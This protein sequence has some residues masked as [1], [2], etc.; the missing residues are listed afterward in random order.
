MLSLWCLKHSVST[1]ILH[2]LAEII[3]DCEGIWSEYNCLFVITRDTNLRPDGHEPV[4][5]NDLT[6]AADM[7]EEIAKKRLYKID[8]WRVHF[9]TKNSTEHT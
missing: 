4:P 8:R 5:K 7:E 3:L 2:D 1:S 9:W 6:G